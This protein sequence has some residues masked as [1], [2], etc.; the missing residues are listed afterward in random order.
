MVYIAAHLRI[1]FPN[2]LHQY[3]KHHSK[4]IF[5]RNSIVIVAEL[6]AKEDCPTGDYGSVRIVLMQSAAN[7]G[8][9]ELGYNTSNIAGSQSC[10][11]LYLSKVF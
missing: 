11:S 5:E 4:I 3:G 7:S 2:T 6:D 1:G 9:E 8:K 10:Q